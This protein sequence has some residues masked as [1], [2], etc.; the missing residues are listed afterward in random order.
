MGTVTGIV[1]SIGGRRPLAHL[2]LL[3]L[4][5]MVGCEGPNGG[6]DRPDGLAGMPERSLREAFRLGGLEP[7]P[8]EAFQ[9]AP[10]LAVDRRGWTYALHT[11]RGQ[12]AAFGADG[13]QD[14]L[15]AAARDHVAEVRGRV[16]EQGIP[17]EQAPT[18]PDPDEVRRQVF[19]P[20]HY[21]PIRAVRLGIDGTV[22]VQRTD[23]LDQGPWVALAPD[24]TPQFQVGLP[25]NA[26]LRHGSSEAIWGTEIGEMDV[27]YVVRWEIVPDGG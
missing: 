2:P 5:A 18:V 15:V 12:V 25:E 27:P 3:A 9:R 26:K 23:G 19:L 11:D 24:G 1:G 14:S 20:G 6:T 16:I 17:E 4:V 10:P 21:P 7:P 22:W 8:E 13:V